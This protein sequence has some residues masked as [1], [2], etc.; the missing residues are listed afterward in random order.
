[1]KE[2]FSKMKVKKKEEDEMNVPSWFRL[3]THSFSKERKNQL[4]K[5]L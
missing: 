1:M 4:K 2:D 5:I 3:S